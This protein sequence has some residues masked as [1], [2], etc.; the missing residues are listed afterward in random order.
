M[1]FASCSLSIKA[2]ILNPFSFFAMTE[3][4]N[5]HC[6]VKGYDRISSFKNNRKIEIFNTGWISVQSQDKT[7][8][9]KTEI[10]GTS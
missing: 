4:T 6:K 7:K 8:Y 2:I 1:V 9:I 5:G 10:L 3:M